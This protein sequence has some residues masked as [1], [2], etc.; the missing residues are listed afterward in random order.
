MVIPKDL[1][2]VIGSY[3]QFEEV[4]EIFKYHPI[5]RDKIINLYDYYISSIRDACITGKL[6]V[7]EYLY[8]IY[9]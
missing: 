2:F 8:G 5:E 1:I 4:L 9:R 7:F 3:L 6:I